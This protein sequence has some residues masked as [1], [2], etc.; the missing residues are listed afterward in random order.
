MDEERGSG[1]G[2]GG[3]VVD[4]TG[5]SCFGGAAGIGAAGTEATGTGGADTTGACR[6]YGGIGLGE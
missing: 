6:V 4:F 3:G 5:S 1:V 2:G